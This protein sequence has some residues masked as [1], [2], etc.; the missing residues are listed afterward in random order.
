MVKI[1]TELIKIGTD[2]VKIGTE[3]VKIGTEWVKFG[4]GL[5]RISQNWSNSEQNWSNWSKSERFGTVF[6]KVPNSERSSDNRNQWNPWL[7]TL[8]Y[9]FKIVNEYFKMF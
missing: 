1:G 9:S 7:N 3:L 8:H 4:T 6:Q 2:F 5:V